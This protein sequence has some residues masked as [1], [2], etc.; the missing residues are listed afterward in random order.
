MRDYIKVGIKPASV[1]KAF[2]AFYKGTRDDLEHAL[3][4]EKRFLIMHNKAQRRFLLNLDNVLRII[5][6][7]D[8]K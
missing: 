1:E 8:S 5:V 6:L 4:T 7:D 2:T 3:L